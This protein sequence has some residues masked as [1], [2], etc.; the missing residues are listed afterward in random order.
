MIVDGRPIVREG[1]RVVMSAAPDLVVVAQVATV[2]EAKGADASPDVI[3]AAF[4]LPDAT[5]ENMIGELRRLAPRA[6]ILV[7]TPISANAT[8]Q[9]L[10]A[11]GAD[12]YLLETADASDVLEGIR[13]LGA[14][15]TYLQPSLGVQLARLQPRPEA[16]PELSLTEERLLGLL[17]L[18]HTNAEVAHLCG[19]SL[20]TVEARRARLRQTLGRQTR[21]ELVEYARAVGLL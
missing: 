9:N 4:D 15:K 8:L 5:H 13:T 19:V 1:L 6:S 11:T 2:A 14:G 7:V 10:L 21:A 3:V 17:A 12:G 20:R 18:G 16:T